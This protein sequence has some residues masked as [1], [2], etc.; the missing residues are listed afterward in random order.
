MNLT[1]CPLFING[2][3]ITR[4]IRLFTDSNYR[5]L[6]SKRLVSGFRSIGLLNGK[7]EVRFGLVCGKVIEP[8]AKSVADLFSKNG[9]LLWPPSDVAGHIRRLAGLEYENNLATMIAKILERN[10]S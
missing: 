8:E 10:P 5:K 9:W 3:W 4:T 6:V 2:E 7:V 1:P